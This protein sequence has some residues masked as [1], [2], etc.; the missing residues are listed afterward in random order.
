MAATYKLQGKTLGDVMDGIYQ[1]FG[2]FVAGLKNV[3]FT[4]DAQKAK[5][6]ALLDEFRANP[7]KEMAGYAV[8]A[9]P[10]SRPVPSG[11]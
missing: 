7:P 4:S 10:T 6:M 8:T 3:V 1:R 11:M 2:Y 9:V 5:C